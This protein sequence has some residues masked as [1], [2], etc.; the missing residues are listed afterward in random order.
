MIMSE[1]SAR[2]L[3]V[4]LFGIVLSIGLSALT[5]VYLIIAITS[6]IITATPLAELVVDVAIPAIIALGVFAILW[7]ASVMSLLWALFQWI[8]QIESYQLATVF[9]RVEEIIPP[10]SVF[11]LPARFTPMPASIERDLSIETTRALASLRR[12]YV[13]GDISDATFERRMERLLMKSD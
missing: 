13:I 12:Q 6:G 9:A 10:I 3:W 4:A 7:I 8:M 11:H 2:L 5:T 1:H